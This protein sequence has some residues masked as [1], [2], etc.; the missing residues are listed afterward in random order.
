MNGTTREMGARIVELRLP[1][2]EAFGF[3]DV[4]GV[5]I[6]WQSFGHGESAVLVV[7]TWNF[8]DSRVSAP[9]VPDLSPW[10]RVIT[11]DPRGAGR[12]DRPPTGYGL[13]DHVADALAVLQAAGVARASLVAGSSG[14]NIA[15]LLAARSPD[16]V[17]RLVLVGAAID[18][19]PA[20][21]SADFNDDE[22][23]IERASYE[24][25]ERW[26][27]PYWRN[28][29]PGF[30]R[31]FLELAFNEPGSE[32]LIDAILPIA[33][34]ADPEILIEQHREQHLGRDFLAAPAILDAI[35]AP[36]LVL[37]G[38]LDRSV[39]LAV[40]GAVTA[41]IPDAVLA[42]VVAGGHRPDIRSPELVDPLLV[43][44]LRGQQL[45][46]GPGIEIRT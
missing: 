5:Q 15:A 14:A 7:P 8:V 2:P 1:E 21:S 33:L 16:Q 39:P 26:S 43:D 34:E 29:W 10:F 18:V 23:W 19:G 41:A 6:A 4:A 40:A 22:F 31:W 27:A 38:E 45:T 35:S 3:A 36:T 37:H 17:Q 30:A 44:F 12:S 20:S 24:G 28:D 9:L 25:W 11:F 32:E 42:V 46:A 13:D